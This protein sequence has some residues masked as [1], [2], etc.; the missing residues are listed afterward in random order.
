MTAPTPPTIPTPMVY[1]EQRDGSE[2]QYTSLTGIDCPVDEDR[3]VQSGAEDADINQILRRFHVTGEMPA[4]PSAAPFYGD[5]TQV[6]DFQSALAA[7]EEAEETFNQLPAEVRRRFADDPAE[8]IDFVSDPAN[9]AEAARL[10]LLTPPP[11]PE[12]PST[13]VVPPAAA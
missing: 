3:A 9:R 11:I 12:V 7:L 6:T 8:L 2:D 5:F 13:P 4:P 10:G 1:R